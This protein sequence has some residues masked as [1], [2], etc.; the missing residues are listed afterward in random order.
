MPETAR[1]LPAVQAE[2]LVAWP[3]VQ[4]YGYGNVA[5]NLDDLTEAV[6]SADPDIA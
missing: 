2:Q 3:T 5:R 6:A 1:R 4:A